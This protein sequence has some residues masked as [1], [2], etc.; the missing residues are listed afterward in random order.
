MKSG[1]KKQFHKSLF[2]ALAVIVAGVIAG[3]FLMKQKNLV[4]NS[5][6]NVTSKISRTPAYTRLPQPDEDTSNWKIY[7]DPI[8]KFSI[9]Y[10]RSLEI[11]PKGNK[12]GVEIA[13]MFVN[14]PTP[15]SELGDSNDPLQIIAR[16]KAGKD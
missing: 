10:P 9:K 5:V 11:D 16:G 2:I 7:T 8:L 4:S 14:S 6:Q 1:K 12:P 3:I 13:W 15:E